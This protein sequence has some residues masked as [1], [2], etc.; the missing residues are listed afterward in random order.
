MIKGHY[1]R[2]A[3][4]SAL[5]ASLATGAHAA[6][7]K[8]PKNWRLKKRADAAKTA[9]AVA[10]SSAAARD[11]G[12]LDAGRWTPEVRAALE[13]FIAE[14]GKDAAGY[15][16][17]K[18]PVAVFPW[19]DAAVAGDP[20]E[21]VFLR[22]VTDVKFTSSEEW[23]S[24]VPVGYG[25]QPAR[26]GFGQFV[27]LSTTVWTAQP[28]YHAWRKNMLS[29]YRDLCRGVGRR[30][31]RSYLAR[32]WTGWRAGDA[33]DYAYRA[34]RDERARESGVE[35]IPGEPGDPNPLKVRRGLRLIPE[36][37]ELMKRLVE[38]G[39]D[40]W[41]IDDLPQPVLAA[42]AADYGIDPSRVQ[43]IRNNAAGT[44]LGPG[45]LRPVPTRAGKTEIVQSNLG[46]P[47]DLVFG[48]DSADLE[49]MGY[50]TGL[51]VA[52][53]GDPQLEAEAAARGWLIQPSLAR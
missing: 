12:R 13:R 34:L 42:S 4:F 45:V 49:L 2:N 22:L 32:L 8:R 15:D 44:R 16:A 39:I 29:S 6:A 53:A 27:A 14:K 33:E 25:R 18:P 36:M 17:Q 9:P 5:I 1:L 38:A 7:K 28:G 21:L 30:E 37:K 46:R 26:A 23:W 35:E 31:C 48:R 11:A 10:A 51:R 19:S 24:L 52:L 20:A 3:L 43:G 41:V 40:V 50:G 47:A